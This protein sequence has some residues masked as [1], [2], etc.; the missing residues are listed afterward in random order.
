MGVV[1][2]LPAWA[3]SLEPIFKVFMDNGGGSVRL[4]Y[5]EGRETRLELVV[6]LTKDQA[7]NVAKALGL[8]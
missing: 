1:V 8:H 7:A 5:Q 4:N 2:K 3:L 6:N